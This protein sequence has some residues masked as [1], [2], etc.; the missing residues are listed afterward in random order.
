MSSK[1]GW[2][3]SKE[4]YQREEQNLYSLLAVA[5]RSGKIGQQQ[6]NDI[7]TSIWQKSPSYSSHSFFYDTLSCLRKA[8]FFAKRVDGLDEFRKEVKNIYFNLSKESIYQSLIDAGFKEAAQLAYQNMWQE[9][10][11]KLDPINTT[12]RYLYRH[13]L[14]SK[15]DIEYPRVDCDKI[16]AMV[17]AGDLV[18]A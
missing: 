6:Y 15:G 17:K 5:L 13:E 10:A 7:W 9:A 14:M 2:E 8:W 16:D 12:A 1:Q 11:Q 4:E 3:Q 18:R